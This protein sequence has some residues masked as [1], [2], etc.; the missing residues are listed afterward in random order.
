MRFG[1]VLLSPLMTFHTLF[2]S[3][4]ATN[5]FHLSRPIGDTFSANAILRFEEDMRWKYHKRHESASVLSSAASL[6]SCLVTTTRYQRVDCQ[7]LR[8]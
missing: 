6:A 1:V 5:L 8:S 7:G 3:T 2:N 4:T